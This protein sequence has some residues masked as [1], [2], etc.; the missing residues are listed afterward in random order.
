MPNVG[1]KKFPYTPKGMADAKDYGMNRQGLY[2]QEEA[3]AGTQTFG[4]RSNNM[5]TGGVVSSPSGHKVVDGYDYNT[6]R[7]N[8]LEEL[9]RVDSEKAR[10]R[11]GKRNL[12]DEKKRIVKELS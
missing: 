2:P 4:Q 12:K 8:R 11:K 1:G 6:S 7:E 9:G 10:T 5:A 3:R